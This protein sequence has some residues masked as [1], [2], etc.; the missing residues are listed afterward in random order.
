MTNHVSHRYTT[1][2]VSLGMTSHCDIWWSITTTLVSVF[3]F[4][5]FWLLWKANNH[6]TVLYWKHRYVFFN[7]LMMVSH[8]SQNM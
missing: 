3:R 7:S 4:C 2:T 5:M 8:K 6:S 1:V